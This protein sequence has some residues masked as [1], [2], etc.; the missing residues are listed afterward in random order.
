[1]TLRS[2]PSALVVLTLFAVLSYGAWSERREEAFVETFLARA[3]AP[4]QEAV[5][6]GDSSLLALL[7]EQTLPLDS[8]VTVDVSRDELEA[9]LAPGE[10]RVWVGVTKA[11]GLDVELSSL[12][13]NDLTSNPR[14]LAHGAIRSNGRGGFVQVSAAADSAAATCIGLQQWLHKTTANTNSDRHAG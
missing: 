3:P 8:V 9:P 5:A 11:V 14:A 7:I 1:M 4:P 2:I 6:R 10:R 12:R 13:P